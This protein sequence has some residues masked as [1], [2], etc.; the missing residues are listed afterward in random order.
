MSAGLA[1]VQEIARQTT[2]NKEIRLAD[3]CI[4]A[5]EALKDIGKLAAV[6][7]EKTEW[8]LAYELEPIIETA[9]MQFYYWGIV[10]ENPK[11]WGEFQEFLKN[12]EAF[13]LLREKKNHVYQC[14]LVIQVM[15]YNHLDYINEDK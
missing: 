14:D 8:K 6:K 4:C 7:S 15:A 5:M 10:K 11:K 9:A 3:A 12:T 1:T 13:E 2:N